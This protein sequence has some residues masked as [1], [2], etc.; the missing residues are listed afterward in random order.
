MKYVQ[1]KPQPQSPYA[2]TKVRGEEIGNLVSNEETKVTSFR[3]FNVLGPGQS[4]DSNYAAVIPIFVDRLCRGE[5]IE[6]HGNGTQTRDFVNVKDVSRALINAAK[7]S[8][9]SNNEVINL[10]TGSGITVLELAHLISKIVEEE[11]GPSTSQILF[12]PK[13]RAMFGFLYQTTQG[14]KSIL[15]L[16]I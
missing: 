6:I 7:T 15:I 4:P 9:K 13:G 14:L 5:D 11:G 1:H 16:P 3:F 10:G 8:L 2:E 12:S